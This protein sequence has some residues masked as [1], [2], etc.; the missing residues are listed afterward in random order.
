MKRLALVVCL[1][2]ALPLLAD[3]WLRTVRITIEPPDDGQ[4]ILNICFSPARTVAYDQ[5]T[6]ECVYHQQFAWHDEHGKP[7]VKVLEPVV[8]TYRRPQAR[9]VDEL[10]FNVSFRVPVSYARL[11]DAFGANAFAT[12]APIVV[13]RLRIR[14]ERGEARLWEQELKVPGAYAI[15]TK[16]APPPPPPPSKKNTFGDVNLD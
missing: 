7:A 13:D 15:E 10:D 2:A 1:L 14:G 8:F 16:A 6:F 9:M 4:Q 11:S 12:N 3:E 5:L